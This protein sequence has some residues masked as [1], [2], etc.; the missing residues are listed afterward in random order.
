MMPPGNRIEE[1]EAEE[2]RNSPSRCA[3]VRL[4][5]HASAG[6][7]I[8]VAVGPII[9]IAVRVSVAVRARPIR[10]SGS[11]QAIVI[12][13][14]ITIAIP[15]PRPIAIRVPVPPVRY[16][17]RLWARR[18]NRLAAPAM[19]MSAALLSS[20]P[21]PRRCRNMQARLTVRPRESSKTRSLRLSFLPVWRAPFSGALRL[22]ISYREELDL[23]RCVPG[24]RRSD[25]R[26]GSQLRVTAPLHCRI[27]GA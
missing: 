26:M 13:R 3:A 23:P 24:D 25:L 9:P 16:P 1:S 2:P 20:G 19:R 22:A 14:P 10:V 12:P 4:L 21:P 7:V 17:I 18:G 5:G 27:P 6:P 8:P 11:G 15:I